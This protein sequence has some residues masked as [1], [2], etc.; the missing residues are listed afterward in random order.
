MAKN[1]LQPNKSEIKRLPLSEYHELDKRG[2]TPIY[3]AGTG[4]STLRAMR[5]SSA[6]T[7]QNA[8]RN[9]TAKRAMM[10]QTQLV[11]EAELKQMEAA[12]DKTIKDNAAAKLQG[13]IKRKTAQNDIAKIKQSVDKIGSSAKR[14]MTERANSY[15][16]PKFKATTIWNEKTVG[17]PLA[18]SRTKKLVSKKKHDAAVEGYQNRL[19]FLDVADKYKDV[20][21]GG[22]K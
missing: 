4:D 12:K 10:K 14:L 11:R 3:E 9:R 18:V 21:K 16:S 22:K 5:N 7:L 17:Q 19:A 20:M 1:G 8:A 2:V 6:I 15:Y 13:T